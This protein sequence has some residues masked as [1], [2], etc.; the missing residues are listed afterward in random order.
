MCLPRE[1]RRQQD[2]TPFGSH[3]TSGGRHTSVDILLDV[4]VIPRPLALAEWPTLH[5]EDHLREGVH[6]KIVAELLGHAAIS[7]TLDTYSHVLPD[8][9]R[10]ATAAMSRA[11]YSRSAS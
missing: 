1:Q 9:M 8:M 2:R 3:F 10:Y 4:P 6:P 5:C 11:L 7:I